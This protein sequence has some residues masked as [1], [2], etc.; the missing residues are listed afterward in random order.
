MGEIGRRERRFSTDTCL[1]L[2]GS[3][4]IVVICVNGPGQLYIL[5]CMYAIPPKVIRI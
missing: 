4:I 1:F 2:T 3:Y 5:I